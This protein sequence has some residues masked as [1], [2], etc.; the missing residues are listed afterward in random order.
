MSIAGTD[1]RT[2]A[3][4]LHRPCS[5]HYAGNINEDALT[6]RDLFEVFEDAVERQVGA[7]LVGRRTVDGGNVQTVVGGER[8]CLAEVPVVS[9][10][11][12]AACLVAG[13]VLQQVRPVPFLP[14]FENNKQNLF[15]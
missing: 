12:R 9:T 8:S 1:G 7:A 10:N 13:Q 11:H 14:P 3:L 15:S 6:H 4:P 2:D 5:A